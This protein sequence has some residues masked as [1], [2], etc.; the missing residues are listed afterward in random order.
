M[1]GYIRLVQDTPLDGLEALL[2]ESEETLPETDIG[3]VGELVRDAIIKRLLEEDPDRMLQMIVSTQSETV[4]E[5]VGYIMG[6]LIERKGYET[7]HAALVET[8]YPAKATRT[9]RTALNM[10]TE[11][12]AKRFQLA[13]EDG[14]F[15]LNRN[16]INGAGK[17]AVDIILDEDRTTELDSQFVQF[18]FLHYYAKDPE[19][20]QANLVELTKASDRQSA[21]RGIGQAWA[22]R[23]IGRA[24]DD[25][26]GAQEFAA[27]LESDAMRLEF[28]RSAMTTKSRIG[29]SDSTGFL[30]NIIQ[31]EDGH[32][33]STL[34]EEQL[35]I[36]KR[37]DA[38]A[39]RKWAEE[40]DQ[41]E[42]FENL[43]IDPKPEPEV[44]PTLFPSLDH[45]HRGNSIDALLYED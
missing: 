15:D 5:E 43:I 28:L 22:L 45:R 20:T 37:V 21:I 14:R 31:L 17:E 13:I 24:A 23:G 18:S 27:G 16:W 10:M 29:A 12:R 11:D 40:N 41:L 42:T 25:I 7:V 6:E 36:L 39:A 19:A 34:V 38:G 9:I 26:S 4:A 2:I 1:L 32:L 44:D 33:R 35:S 3:G 30:Q 8:Q